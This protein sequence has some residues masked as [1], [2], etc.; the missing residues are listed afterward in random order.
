[1]AE[2]LYVAVVWT[3]GDIITE[4]KMDNMVAN[5][6][7]VDAMAQGIQLAERASP[8]TPSANNLH[9]FAKDKDGVACLFYIDD[10]GQEYQLGATNPIFTF[11]VAGNLTTGTRLTSA[12]I[13]PKDL[14]IIKAYAY[15]GTAP[16]N[17][18]IIIDINK[19]NSSIWAST[20]GNRL[21]IGSGAQ[22]ASQT[23]FDV[24]T[25]AE[26]D[27]LTLDID[28]VGATIAGADLTVELKTQL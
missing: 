6:R 5:D 28:Q 20:Q 25:L 17:A 19:N 14:E 23:S 8:S 26:G 18:S 24:T 15:V 7:A 22:S 16:T 21:A 13:V 1:M 27:I 4:A 2:V 10:A 9:L 12:L 11:P 3:A